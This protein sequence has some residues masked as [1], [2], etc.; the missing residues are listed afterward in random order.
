MPKRLVLFL[1]ICLMTAHVKAD[2]TLYSHPLYPP[3]I[4]SNADLQ[5]YT[6]TPKYVP[7]NLYEAFKILGANDPSVID[8]FK[9]RSAQG[10]LDYGLYFPSA[11]MR[12]EFCLEGYSNFVRYFHAKGIYYPRAMESYILLSFHQYLNQVKIDWHGNKAV[13]LDGEAKWNRVWRKRTRKI[14]NRKG[15]DVKDAKMKKTKK[16]DQDLPDK[17]FWE[18]FDAYYKF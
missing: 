9:K 6:Y 15:V 8:R 14:F 17:R 7:R 13:A 3:L 12:K 18:E 1:C 11:R 16:E 5:F 2:D 10:V 4:Y